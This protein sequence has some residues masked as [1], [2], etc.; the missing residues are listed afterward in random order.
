V[1]VVL[2]NKLSESENVAFPRPWSGT[3]AFLTVPAQ[4][5][6]S[7]I[8]SA[9]SARPSTD[10]PSAAAMRAACAHALTGGAGQHLIGQ[11]TNYM[12]RIS[13]SSEGALGPHPAREPEPV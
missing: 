9:L 10:L 11:A 1:P 5:G 4:V 6:S 3:P 12:T 8:L 2:I 7:A 13:A